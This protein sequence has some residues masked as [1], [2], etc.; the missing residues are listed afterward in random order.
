MTR[1]DTHS[2]PDPWL[3]FMQCA[4]PL[5]KSRFALPKASQAT[6]AKDPSSITATAVVAHVFVAVSEAKCT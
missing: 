5:K 3:Q 6:V 1:K 2:G 4:F